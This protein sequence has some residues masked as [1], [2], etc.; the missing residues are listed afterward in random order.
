MIKFQSIILILPRVRSIGLSKLVRTKTN[1]LATT[2]LHAE[3][4]I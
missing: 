3:A 4:I 2:T 1:R